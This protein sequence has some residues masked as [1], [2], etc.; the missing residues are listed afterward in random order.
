MQINIR[1]REVRVRRKF[2]QKLEGE[3]KFT[4]SKTYAVVGTL[5]HERVRLSL[6]A[7]EKN[8]AVRRIAKIEKAVGEGPYSGLWAELAETLPGKTFKFF[9]DRVGYVGH[10][11]TSKSIFTWQDLTDAYEIDMQRRIDNKERG[12]GREEG[13]MSLSTRD[14]YR[15]TINHLESFLE[16]KQT[17]LVEITP[18]LITKF[19]VQR[20]KDIT[21]LKQSRGGTSVALDIA[22]LHAIFAF[23]V[24]QK[25]MKDKPIDLSKE[26]KPGKN[27]KNGARPF[28]GGEL[29]KI[30]EV[31]V[32]KQ[33]GQSLIDDTHCFLILRW[34][35]LR[36]S[37]AVNLRWGHI[38]FDRG[39][40]GEVEILTQKRSKIAI[41]P[42]S[43]ELR[44]MLEDLYKGRKP[45]PED[46][47]LW[48]PDTKLPFSS[49][50][51]LSVRMK[52][53]C[54]RA[55]VKGSAH[56]F[57]DTFV[58]DMLARGVSIYDV[59]QMVADTVETIEKHY[60]QFVP[61][62]RDAAQRKMDTGVGIEEQ[63][64]IAGQ[65]GKKVVGIRG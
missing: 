12:A 41:I 52:S 37:D 62:A 32:F 6:G 33:K 8:V 16:N 39:A 54:E 38:H 14:R 65:R 47:V 23:A 13:I 4:G 35:G 56:C 18:A 40:N 49:R 43:S 64:K 22:I 44:D 7:T 9:A 1:Y 26:S 21:A 45:Q 42:L 15:T 27:P 36:I 11:P 3:G 25:M 57:R 50:V 48:N 2:S 59:A 30:R 19:K 51:R 63:A 61:A 31:V 10:A 5:N 34:L 20:H 24:A 17:P 28:T 46:R 55:G 58:A 53:L 29:T 60:A